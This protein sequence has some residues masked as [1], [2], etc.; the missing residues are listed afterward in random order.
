MYFVIHLILFYL[1][2]LS[3][4]SFIID[5]NQ[6]IVIKYLEKSNKITLIL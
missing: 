1:K 2:K 5:N 3:L 4:F 6:I